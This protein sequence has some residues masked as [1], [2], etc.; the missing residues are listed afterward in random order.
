MVSWVFAMC[1]LKKLVEF[2][3]V[4]TIGWWCGWIYSSGP[5][6][7]QSLLGRTTCVLRKV[8]SITPHCLSFRDGCYLDNWSVGALTH[9]WLA[10]MVYRLSRAGDRAPSIVL[11]WDRISHWDLGHTDFRGAGWPLSPAILVSLPHIGIT[12]TS[13]HSWIFTWVLGIELE[14]S[15]LCSKPPPWCSSVFINPW[16]YIS[17]SFSPLL[18]PS[19]LMFSFLLLADWGL[20][21]PSVAG[22]SPQLMDFWRSDHPGTSLVS[23][24]LNM[25]RPM[26]SPFSQWHWL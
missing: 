13:C 15:Y 23:S 1:F 2:L 7:S 19:L 25:F 22:R 17:L 3:I 10:E 8:G 16:T 24:I 18:F 21:G 4:W 6:T 9:H 14:S 20:T 26:V 5:C 11:F 12:S